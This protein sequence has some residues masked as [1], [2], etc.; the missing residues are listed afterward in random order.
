MNRLGELLTRFLVENP[1]AIPLYVLG[2]WLL[3][4]R[5]L[6]NAR[7]RNKK[8]LD[9]LTTEGVN[10]DRFLAFLRDGHHDWISAGRIFDRVYKD[11]LP[12]PSECLVSARYDPKGVSVL[13]T[14][15]F[16]NLLITA[17]ANGEQRSDVRTVALDDIASCKTMN[18]W[19]AKNRK[20]V[21]TMVD[22]ERLELQNL[23]YI[24]SFERLS[25]LIDSQKSKSV[26]PVASSK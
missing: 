26:P 23:T 15:E 2:F 13:L 5:P 18:A 21:I 20:A 12:L 1:A 10:Y 6:L 4:I 22:G 7:E 19:Q 3:V 11:R 8:P 17:D 9:Q 25:K 14:T 16:L 24:R